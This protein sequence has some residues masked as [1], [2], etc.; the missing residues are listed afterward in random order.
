M[1]SSLITSIESIFTKLN[2]NNYFIGIMMILLNIGSKYFMQE[3]GTTVDYVLNIK[4]IRRLLIFT[5]FFVAT[6]DIKTSL[7]LTAVF[8]IITLELFNEKSNLCI[9]PKNIIDFMDQNK[10]G[11]ITADE[12]KRSISVLQ[13]AG[14]VKNNDSDKSS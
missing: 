2:N 12:I 6:R 4:I 8:I 1:A 9:I 3:F 13:K 5:V 10:D 14:Y 7:I 11:V